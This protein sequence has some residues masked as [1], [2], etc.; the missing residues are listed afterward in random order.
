MKNL[1][2]PIRFEPSEEVRV[3]VLDLI[4]VMVKDSES[5]APKREYKKIPIV[6]LVPSKIGSLRA[7]V[8]F[9]DVQEHPDEEFQVIVS[10]RHGR[11][12]VNLAGTDGLV[13]ILGCAYRGHLKFLAEMLEQLEAQEYDENSK[14]NR[15]VLIGE[16]DTD[17]WRHDII[18]KLYDW[19]KEF[20]KT[21]EHIEQYLES[22]AKE[23]YTGGDIK[24]Q[25]DIL[26]RLK[27]ILENTDS[28]RTKNATA[29]LMNFLEIFGKTE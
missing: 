22:L 4:E 3:T 24:L 7:V 2:N 6:S 27:N 10:G 18:V 8:K 25:Q 9:Y 23:P 17:V 26:E 11:W 20:G 28:Q 21:G 1:N 14:W 12:E 29:H 16:I 5:K 19:H 13:F 15:E